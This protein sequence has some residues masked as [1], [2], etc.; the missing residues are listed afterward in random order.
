MFE[1]KADRVQRP[2]AAARTTAGDVPD[3]NTGM[4]ERNQGWQ[5][6]FRGGAFQTA[7]LTTANAAMQKISEILGGKLSASHLHLLE[8]SKSVRLGVENGRVMLYTRDSLNVPAKFD[9]GDAE[10]IDIVPKGPNL[11]IS[12]LRKPGQDGESLID[13]I[14]APMNGGRVTHRVTTPRENPPGA[15]AGLYKALFRS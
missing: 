1:V 4:M 8:T 6:M 2:S 11:S 5:N 13:K 10:K 12:I 15:I 7:D 14:I 9:L 3:L